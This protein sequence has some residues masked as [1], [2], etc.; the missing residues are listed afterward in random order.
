MNEKEAMDSGSSRAA[1]L[2]QEVAQRLR[3]QTAT[4]VEGM[5][6][7]D[8]RALLRELQVH[9]IELEMSNEELLRAQTAA[10]QASDK[11]HDLFDFAPI[12]YFRLDGQG[13]ILEVNLAGA[14]LLGLDRSTATKQRFGQFVAME[15]RAA[16][17]EF[18]KRVLATTAKQTC[19]IE[20]RRNE[21]PVYA[22]VEGI[23]AQDG[24]ANRSLRVT[25]T[26]VTE[27]MQAEQTLHEG[28]QRCRD[29]AE[30]LPQTV[31]E[32]ELEGRLTFVNRQALAMFGYTR[33]EFEAGL[34]CFQMLP[35]HE[36]DRARQ[37]MQR[38]VDG[39][40]LGGTEYTA[41]RK[42]GTQFPVIIYSSL[43][44]RQDTPVGLRGIVVDVTESK[45]AQEALAASE[46]CYRRLFE[47]A[48]DGILIL[49]AETGTILDV[50]PFLVELLGYSREQFL[51]KRIWELGVF[52][53]V[54]ASQANFA[55]LQRQ[56]YIRY[57]DLPLETADGRRIEVEFVS[58]VYLADHQKVI[59][60]NIR[61]ITERRIAESERAITIEVLRLIGHTNHRHELLRAV[62]ASLQEWSGCEAVGF[63][64][65]EG[66]DFPYFETRGFPSEFVLAENRLCAVDSRGELQRDSEGIPV[67]ECMC[68]NIIC[69]RFDASKP[70]FTAHGSFWTNSTTELLASTTEADRQAR[71]RNRCNGEG[72]ESVA[73]IPLRSSGE[74]LG[75]LQLNDH[76]KGRFTPRWISLL[77]RL[78]DSV[79]RG[80]AHQNAQES[81]RLR[82]RAINATGEG[83]CITGPNEA[84]NPLIYVNH[85]FEQLTGYPAQ[86][87]LGQNMRFLQGPDTD[88]AV[89]DRM[90]A[91]IASDR[92][93]TT[94][95]LD[96]RKDGTPFWNQISITPV[97]D[98]TGNVD[99]FVAILHDLTERKWAE[100]ALR[101]SED[102]FRRI[103]DEAS[104]GVAI[105]SLDYRFARVN[106][107]LCRI[108]GYSREELTRLTFPDITHPDDLAGDLEQVRQ[109]AEGAIE[110]YVTEK[111]YI[112]KD[113]D[114][115][116]GHLSVRLLRGAAGQPLHF[117]PMIEN[118][119]ARKEDE[120]KLAALQAQLAH[121]SRLATLG[122]LAAGIA[123]E[124][125]QPLCSILNFAKASKNIASG[126]APDLSQIRQWSDS[127][128]MAVARSGDIIRRMLDF[129]RKGGATRETVAVRQLVAEAMLLVRHEAQT[130]KVTLR[131][132]MPDQELAAS[133]DPVQIQQVLV[134]L[135]RNAIEALGD[136]RPADRRVVVQARRVDGLV[137]VSVSDNGSGPPEA[138][139]PKIFEPFFT[140][141][142]QGLGMGLAIS[143]TNIED[144][145]GRIWAEANQSGG[146]TVH[147]TL[148]TGKDKPQDAPEQNGV[149][150]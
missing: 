3:D 150:D 73:L 47:A 5:A 55:E 98:A 64:R 63:R 113:G 109:L 82:D 123:H 129:A 13:R 83:I 51:G 61:D 149:R 100:E 26:D 125:N 106:E 52:K 38:A 69:G 89:V 145:G 136:T 72:Y 45:R 44:L 127:I 17:A 75:L 111:R 103:F 27:R 59:Q 7:V 35:S 114:I 8:V 71:T 141:K 86:E 76:R 81:L 144:P 58:N 130:R 79:A 1:D 68:G 62:T 18:C 14:A 9:Q 97:K 92:E 37:N 48:K 134:N 107:A 118:I 28:E 4:P 50:N 41:Q 124:V 126:E 146:L 53:D 42:D 24:G 56:E 147:F 102:R 21:E 77:E 78:A 39:Q 90:R 33:A 148:P 143:K 31:Y 60:C 120:N 16:F 99:H 133:V 131:Q 85:G 57:E 116:W 12:G 54:A 15:H 132:E 67:L 34:S 80:L 22:V 84:G 108:T 2:R 110:Q 137:Q 11:Y 46:A 135:L 115:I 30:L 70:F 96:Y 112:R 94:E 40:D 101:E 122:E 93:F 36:H 140:T 119:T 65:R 87:V 105:V 29:V 49:D 88:R 20:L 23:S 19:E 121:A 32:V 74:T 95:L 104:I 6:E 142:P 91:A 10:Q 139:L 128:A 117:L 43:I 25:V 138:E 66:E